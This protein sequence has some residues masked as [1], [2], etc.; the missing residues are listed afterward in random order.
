MIITGG[1]IVT[2]IDDI[3]KLPANLVSAANKYL[4]E[5]QSTTTNEE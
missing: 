2:N 1:Y 4:E 3:E 5:A